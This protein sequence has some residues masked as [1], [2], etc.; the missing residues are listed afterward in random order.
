MDLSFL[1]YFHDDYR[2]QAASAKEI[3]SCL[4]TTIGFSVMTN[5]PTHSFFHMFTASVR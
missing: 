5:P 4:P 1:E 2:W 3:E